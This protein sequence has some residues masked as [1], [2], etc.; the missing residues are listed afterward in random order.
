MGN[1]TWIVTADMNGDG[2]PDAVIA[3][4][5]T[6][7]GVSLGNGSGKF[8]TIKDYQLPNAGNIAGLA[9]GDFNGEGKQDV[10]VLAQN[11]NGLYLYLGNGYGTLQAARII[12]TPSFPF[13]LTVGDL[14]GDGI[15]DIVVTN[16]ASPP[17]NGSSGNPGTM[18][19]Y[20][21]K[22]NGTFADPVSYGPGF[23]PRQSTIADIN[24]DGKPDILV[25]SISADYSTGTLSVYL[26]NGDGT[27]QPAINTTCSISISALL[28]SLT[29]TAM[30]SRTFYFR[31]AADWLSPALRLA[32]VTVR[33]PASSL[34]PSISHLLGS[35]QRISIRM[36]CRI[37]S[38]SQTHRL[39]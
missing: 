9:T 18:D 16:V 13:G 35:L 4:S 6:A 21:S 30:A 23:S 34:Y 11:S 32:M 2:K 20:L 36:G 39:A 33:F 27:L 25:D 7:V 1:P 24:N 3:D 28:P 14:N 31:A 5:G 26:G 29:S 19:V 37:F 12:D 8:G 15:P 22:G 38:W 17:D 10:L